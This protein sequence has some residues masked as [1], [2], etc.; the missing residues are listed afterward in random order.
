MI[1]INF[2]F[3]LTNSKYIYGLY[4]DNKLFYIGQTKNANQRLQQ[5]KRTYSKNIEMK[6]FRE[7]SVEVSLHMEQEFIK[8]FS[9]DN[10][11]DNKSVYP[12]NN[13]KIGHI[14]IGFNYPCYSFYRRKDYLGEWHNINNIGYL[15]VSKNINKK[16]FYKVYCRVRSDTSKEEDIKFLTS[17]YYDIYPEENDIKEI[18]IKKSEKINR[19]K[20]INIQKKVNNKLIIDY[21]NKIYT[22]DFG[23]IENIEHKLLFSL[24]CNDSIKR[25]D[26]TKVKVRNY[27]IETD[28]YVNSKT[29]TI[30]FPKLHTYESCD[31]QMTEYECSLYKQIEFTTDYLLEIKAKDRCNSYSKKISKLS[32]KYFGEKLNQNKIRK[33]I[34]NGKIM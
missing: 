7:C 28:A 22:F 18:E 19:H 29:N 5:H 15:Y 3:I 6:I 32:E 25:N 8:L 14:L 23:T 26:L 31:L 12:V 2:D 17:G 13:S 24:I 9:Y 34:M 21:D 16:S 20:D 27:D 30:I 11:L 10:I 33:I 4:K 1:N